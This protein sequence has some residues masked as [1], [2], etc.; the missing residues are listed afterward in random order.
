MGTNYYLRQNACD[1]CGRSDEKLHIGK[2][3]GGWCFSLHV[4]PEMNIRNIDDWREHW[5]KGRIFD[6]YGTEV[7]AA[8]M[9][10]VITQRG[11]KPYDW[12]KLADKWYRDECDFHRLNHS[13][14]GPNNLLRH[15][16]DYKH[17]I[18][19]GE[20]TWDYIIGEFS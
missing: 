8:E 6:E 20:G 13:E 4:I 1:H 19:H 12:S 18:G 7:S 5:V 15:R 9:E 17:C 10:S 14:R 2:S 3:S 16:L 11:R